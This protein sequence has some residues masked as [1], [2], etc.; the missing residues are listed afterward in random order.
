MLAAGLAVPVFCWN[1]EAFVCSHV[2]CPILSKSSL[3]SFTLIFEFILISQW[4]FWF[5]TS[6]LTT[7]HV[8]AGSFFTISSFI[9]KIIGFGSLYNWFDISL[10]FIISLECHVESVISE[11]FKSAISVC[12]CSLNV[13]YPRSRRTSNSFYNEWSDG[14]C[15]AINHSHESI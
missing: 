13:V 11:S 9:S 10:L 14:I 3:K 4:C 1:V 2:R 5:G 6:V 12:Y 7:F 15:A 8:L